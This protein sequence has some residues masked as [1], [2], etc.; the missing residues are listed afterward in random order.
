MHTNEV[1]QRRNTQLPRQNIY[2]INRATDGRVEG[3]EEDKVNRELLFTHSQKT[4][5]RAHPRKLVGERFQTNKRK[6]VS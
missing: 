1:L 2:N 4:K 3:R 5:T 6:Y